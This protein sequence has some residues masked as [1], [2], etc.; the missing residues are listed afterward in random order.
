[1]LLPAGLNLLEEK[2][3][4]TQG[5]LDVS[6]EEL[7]EL[8][9]GAVALIADPTVPVDAELLDRSGKGLKV[10]SNFA[11][12]YDNVDLD[13]CRERGVAVTNTPDVLTEATAEVALLLSLAA[14]RLASDAERDLRAG[15]WTGWNPGAYLGLELKGATVGVVG[16]GRIGI[17]YA[18]MVTALGANVIFSARSAKPDSEEALGARQVDLT[19]LLEQSDLVS[20]HAPGGPETSGMIGRAELELIGPEGVL[21]NTSRGT[22][23]DSLALAE[24]LAGGTLGAAG[25]DVY[26]SEPEVPEELLAAPRCVLLPHIGSATHVSRDAMAETAAANAIAVVEGRE[27]ISRVA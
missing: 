13:A 3:E 17:R 12:G 14:G 27:P 2:F 6:R 21:V 23:V 8:V 1:M 16:L 18:E 19:E 9:P 26:E 4:V 11:V 25:L 15:R 20:L 10:V 22:V 7:F 5:G 24:A